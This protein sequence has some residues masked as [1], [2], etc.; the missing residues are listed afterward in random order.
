MSDKLHEHEFEG[1]VRSAPLCSI[2][3][4]IRDPAGAVMLGLRKNNPA[5][6]FYFVPGGRIRKG[7]TLSDAFERILAT[8]TSLTSTIK[9]ARLIGVYEHFYETNWKN[10]PGFGT[11]YICLAYELYLPERIDV[12]ADTQHSELIWA[13]PSEFDRLRIHPYSLAYLATGTPRK[14]QNEKQQ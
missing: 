10:A 12:T 7:E 8:E 5:H 13:S 2:D 11:H 6:G 9:E 3:V 1:I 14:T 4:V